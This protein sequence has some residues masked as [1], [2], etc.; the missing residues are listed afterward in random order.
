MWRVRERDRPGLLG[1]KVVMG[2]TID[3][4]TRAW[5]PLFSGLP[6]V[7]SP[8]QAILLDFLEQH[9]ARALAALPWAA[10]EIA[11]NEGFETMLSFVRLRGG[12]RVYVT[13][14]AERCAAALGVPVGER[15]HRR[16]LEGAVG[17]SLI[18]VPS[19]W[20]V[21]VALRGL[22]IDEALLAGASDTC[23]VRDFGVTTRAL[24][25]RR[26]RT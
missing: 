10:A 22:A 3:D 23:V 17:S 7:E 21:F 1:T 16:M 26:A 6:A 20:G 24:R 11:G 2:Q 18:E 25:K 5:G 19:A 9:R 4:R 15:T 14:D 12:R 13:G 8:G